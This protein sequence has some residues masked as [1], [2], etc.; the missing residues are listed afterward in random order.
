MALRPTSFWPTKPMMQDEQRMRS[1]PATP[2]PS[3]PIGSPPSQNVPSMLR[4]TKDATASSASSDASSTSGASQ[5]DMT[6]SP[7][8]TKA[9]SRSSQQSYGP[10]ECQ[11]NLGQN[12]TRPPWAPAFAGAR[13]TVATRSLRKSRSHAAMWPEFPAP[14]PNAPSP[15]RPPC[16]RYR[17]WT[18]RD[19]P[20]GG[21]CE[22]GRW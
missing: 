3:S 14:L 5:P 7:E 19:R 1:L 16:G 12:R 10:N 20:D 6:S 15:V 11:R 21:W 22:S 9:S 18:C 17:R 2:S 4:S 8:T 13:F